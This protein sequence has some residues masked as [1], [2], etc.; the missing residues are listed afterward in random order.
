MKHWIKAFRLRTLPLSLSGIICSYFYFTYSTGDKAFLVFSLALTTT[1]LLQI[2]SNLANDYGDGVKGTDNASR[3]GPERGLQS[4][5]ISQKQMLNAIILFSFLSLIA[6]VGLLFAAFGTDNW[7]QLIAFLI[8]GLLAIAAAIKYTVGKSAYGYR[9]LGDLFV[10]IF[11]GL[12]G[13]AGFYLLLEERV[14]AP[15]LLLSLVIGG[16]STLVLN[17]NNMRDIINDKDSGKTTVPVL[18]GS[19]KAKFYHF[20]IALVIVTAIVTFNLLLNVALIWINLIT[21]VPLLF[22][23]FKVA[24]IKE[25][26]R[27]DPELKKIAL[28][29]FFF[30]LMNS[31]LLALC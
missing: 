27:Y 2:L 18:L 24:Q 20:F 12:V 25:P 10:F 7:W 26:K 8:L 15:I 6:G 22:H 13:V 31:I 3:I 29:T 19:E 1:I 21:I 17:L 16:F 23:L 11:F 14:D 5:K 4:G 30:A 28:S 9:A